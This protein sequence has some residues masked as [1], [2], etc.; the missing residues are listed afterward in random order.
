MVTIKIY[1]KAVMVLCLMLFFPL[2]VNAV[3]G[4]RGKFQIEIVH[5]R[6][7]LKAVNA[8]V[9]DL[10][11]ELEK[12]SG[13][14][15]SYFGKEGDVISADIVDCPVDM[16]FDIITKNF[17]HSV[18]YEGFGNGEDLVISSLFIYS[19]EFTGELNYT[20]NAEN[21]A[22][23]HQ[24]DSKQYS[25]LHNSRGEV[26]VNAST[27]V[28]TNSNSNRS[29]VHNGSTMGEDQMISPLV[30][31]SREGEGGA[32]NID[33]P[34]SAEEPILEDVDESP[35]FFQSPGGVAVYALTPVDI[36]PLLSMRALDP[37]ARFDD[38]R[39]AFDNMDLM[40]DQYLPPSPE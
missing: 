15:I 17:N 27:P 23:P 39:P 32:E 35:Q 22:K 34:K 28:N 26:S 38:G 16:G 11:R 21:T 33:V 6:L 14:T 18:V 4:Y 19:R 40:H 31:Y 36:D 2:A 25:S 7:T 10:F 12:Q 3:E 13:V 30:I 5:E 29:V 20:Y 9:R 1:P 37:L 24:K 8:S